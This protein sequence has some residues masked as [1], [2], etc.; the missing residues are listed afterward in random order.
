MNAFEF[1]PQK[2]ASNKAKHGIDFVEAQALWRGR[3]RQ[4]LA[5]SK[6]REMRYLNIGRIGDKYWTVVTTY[7]GNAERIISAYPSSK[8]QIE[9]YERV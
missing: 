1:D 3:V 9:F 4:T 5:D 6:P 2:S 8:L 7:R